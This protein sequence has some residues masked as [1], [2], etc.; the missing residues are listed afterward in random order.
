MINFIDSSYSNIHDVYDVN[1]DWLIIKHFKYYSQ[2]LTDINDWINNRVASYDHI[3]TENCDFSQSE[4][5]DIKD[6][7]SSSSLKNLIENIT[8]SI[9]RCS[10]CFYGDENPRTFYDPTTKK[11]DG[12]FARLLTI[13][14]KDASNFLQN[15]AMVKQVS[16]FNCDVMP[17]FKIINNLQA[18]CK[19]AVIM[20][21]FD[22]ITRELL[23]AFKNYKSYSTT[24]TENSHDAITDCDIKKN[25]ITGYYN[26][27]KIPGAAQS[28]PNTDAFST[29]IGNY[30]TD[31]TTGLTDLNTLM[32]A[33]EGFN[34]E[35][36]TAVKVLGAL[37]IV[38]YADPADQE[39]LQKN[40][41]ATFTSMVPVTGAVTDTASMKKNLQLRTIWAMCTSVPIAIEAQ[42]YINNLRTNQAVVFGSTVKAAFQN[43]EFNTHLNILKGI[44]ITQH[45]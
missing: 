43:M 6:D 30:K 34:D 20:Y 9:T 15:Y 40:S 3:T 31:L 19:N 4:W 25:M 29:S 5:N 18:Y 17:I 26:R 2:V 28:S 8:T 1:S 37:N 23:T 24:H 41:K 36:Y 33:M 42:Q 45:P 32:D 14:D 11:H 38:F 22:N 44:L 35:V 27:Y 39:L 21:Y 16:K 7:Y 12:I 10:T 13:L